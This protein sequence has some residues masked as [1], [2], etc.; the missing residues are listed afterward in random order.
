MHGIQGETTDV[1][2][3]GPGVDASGLYVG[4]TRGRLHNEA[5]AIAWTTEAARE[6]L[7]DSM[8][9]GLQEVSVEESIRAARGE[10]GRAARSRRADAGHARAPGPGGLLVPHGVEEMRA[11][12]EAERTG[13]L[14][15]EA[16]I[17]SFEARSHSRTTDVSVLAKLRDERDARVGQLD[18][19]SRLLTALAFRSAGAERTT[20][21]PGAARV[22]RPVDAA[23]TPDSA[24]PSL[25]R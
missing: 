6:H 1:S 4:M 12:L 18:T 13:I 23:V 25:E 20:R 21:R 14:A 9:R 7:A 16:Q 22:G 24:G 10:L 3:V 11:G 5:I 8:M 17:A 15:L 2:I 19:A